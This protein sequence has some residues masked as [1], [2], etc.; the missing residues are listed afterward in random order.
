[1][2]IDMPEIGLGTWQLKGEECTK[3]VREAI[4]MGYRHIDTA[5]IYGNEREIGLAIG[6][7]ERD[8]LFITSKVWH[9][10]LHYEEVKD[11]CLA[12]LKRLHADYLDLYLIHWPDPEVPLD[13]TFRAFE[14]LLEEGK[15]KNI[16]VSNFT[17]ERLKMALEVSNVPIVT[18]QIEFHPLLN[19]HHMLEFCHKK[20]V[21]VTAYSPLGRGA[22]LQLDEVK[23]IADELD[24]TEA[25]VAL[26]WLL[27][28]G[29]SAIPKA[30]SIGHLKENLESRE[31]SLT[32]GQMRNLD[33]INRQERFIR[34]SFAE[35]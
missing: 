35:F 18:N 2:I 26:A 15:V 3:V 11:A 20:G 32:E 10:H 22:V 4:K 6:E 12:S 27:K 1:M 16:G 30:S 31:V 25:Q 8:K 34:P 28:K 23:K 13:E 21:G 14:E 24:C 7:F 17:A 29:M 9:S 19:Q 33:G 5:E